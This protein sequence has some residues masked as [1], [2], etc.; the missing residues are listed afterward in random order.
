MKKIVSLLVLFVSTVL[1][2]TGCG[3]KEAPGAPKKAGAVVLE[4]VEVTQ[5]DALVYLD[6]VGAQASSFDQTPDWAPEPN[7]MAPVDGDMLTRWSSDYNPGD[8][9]ISFDFGKGTVV[10]NVIVRWERAYATDYKI[11]ASKDGQNWMEV[12]HETEAGGGAIEASFPPVKCRY[13][14]VVAIERVEDNWG[15]SIWEVE[16]FGPKSNNPD[17]VMTK[18][19]YLTRGEDEGKEQELKALLN[20]LAAP[21]VPLSEK[22][23]QHGICYTSWM[24]DEFGSVASDFTLA[25][26]KQ[27]GYDSVSI[28]VPGYQ[29]EINSEKV[30]TNDH[31]GGDTPTLEALKHAVETCHKIGLRVMIK[32]HIDPRTDEPRINIIANE[33]WFDSYEEFIL[34]YARFSEENKVA[35]FAVGTELEGTSFSAW[36]ARWNQV[37]QKTREIY[38][39][40][41]LYAAN[42]TEYKEVPFWNSVDLIGIDAYFPLT[43]SDDPTVQELIDSWGAYADKIAKWLEENGLTEKGVIFSEIGYTSTQGTNRMP[44]VAISTKEDQQEQAD[45]FEALFTVMSQK[46]WFKGYYVW[47]YF[48]QERWSP[49]GF[50]LNEKKAE[51][52]LKKWLKEVQ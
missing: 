28:I 1:I 19:Q 41:I 52:V 24:D 43:D 32:P 9:W 51:E 45:C 48:P 4:A 14:K 50:T 31:P 38:S 35:M 30:F 49:L 39:G 44:W 47:Q 46:P 7:A 29:M 21:V 16:I 25:K 3:G 2:L 11:M 5:G 36:T 20:K 27:M 8:Q 26:V 13:L 34:R 37:I 23:F 22:P 18:E 15:V 6:V 12:Y 10:S 42:W 40:V 33:K 17:A